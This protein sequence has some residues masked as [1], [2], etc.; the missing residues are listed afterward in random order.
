MFYNYFGKS[1]GGAKRVSSFRGARLGA[2]AAMRLLSEERLEA[3]S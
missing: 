1:Q 3:A 2:D